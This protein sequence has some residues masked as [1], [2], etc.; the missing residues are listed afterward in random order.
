MYLIAANGK[1][2]ASAEGWPNIYRRLGF[3]SFW[4]RISVSGRW[5]RRFNSHNEPGIGLGI[6]VPGFQ[7]P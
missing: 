4:L 1:S 2:R 6:S 3:A 7:T 5:L